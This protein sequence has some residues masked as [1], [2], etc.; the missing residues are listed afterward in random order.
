VNKYMQDAFGAYDWIGKT[1]LEVFPNEMGEKLAEDDV[2]SM[3]LG[4]QKIEESLLQLDGKIH[5]Y[6]TQKFTIDKHG[7]EPWL[8]GISLDITDRMLAEGKLRES[9]EK[10]SSMISNI[11]DVIGIMGIDGKMI[12]KSPNIEKYFGWKPEDLIGTDGWLTVHPDDVDRIQSEFYQLLQ[13]NNSFKTVEYKYLCKDGSYKPIELTA[14]NLVNNKII[15][16]VL[17][18]YHDITERKKGEAEILKAKNEA[19]KANHAK[20]EFL[21]RMSHELRTPMNSILG[22]AQL[23]EMGELNPKQTKGVNYILTSGKYLLKLID[24]VLDISRIEAGKLSLS[25]EPVQIDGLVGEMIDSLQPLLA[26]KH[27]KIELIN[28]AIEKLYIKSDRQRLKQVLLNLLTNAVKYNRDNGDI[29]ISIKV[30]PQNGGG[31]T[32]VRI[33]IT[34]TGLGISEEG[35]SKIFTPFERIGA[36]KTSTEGTGLGLAVVKKLMDAMHGTIGIE[37]TLNVGSTFWI[38]FEQSQS[39]D[40]KTAHQMPGNGIISG[41]GPNIRKGTVL[42]IEDNE[43]NIELIQQTLANQRPDIRLVSHQTG[44]EAVS[45]AVDFAPDL[46]LLDLDLPDLHGSEVFELLKADEKTK[47]IPV[48]IISADAMPQQIEKLL[49]LGVKKYLTKPLDL[50]DFLKVVDEWVGGK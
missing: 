46:I 18:N 25:L 23:L 20:S 7:M 34:D 14:T 2:N 37:S 19:E 27:I 5:H 41:T 32:M 48:V 45:L 4:F 43:S 28:P 11:S 16:G 29:S 24:E 36:E 47:N 33:S 42:Y 26:S 31:N 35:I 50:M 17:L 39:L 15:G 1:M 22:F 12:Y 9:E 3:E 40:H 44:K 6:E 10:H 13:N 8:G 49:K 21:S 30:M 38:E